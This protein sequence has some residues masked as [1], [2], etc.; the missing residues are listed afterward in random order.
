MMNV[1]R[2]FRCPQIAKK[3]ND[4]KVKEV[5]LVSIFI[6]FFVVE[7]LYA[8]ESKDLSWWHS[9]LYKDHTTE[10]TIYSRN[11]F[12]D[13]VQNIHLMESD[14]NVEKRV[15]DVQKSSVAMPTCVNEVSFGSFTEQQRTSRWQK[16]SFVAQSELQLCRLW[17]SPCHA[18]N[19]QIG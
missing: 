18:E 15:K 4:C 14:A 7:L 17:K 6:Y 8:Y 2:V 1:C 16:A 13:A 3:N 10:L 9:V 11:K 5:I 12:P 19:G